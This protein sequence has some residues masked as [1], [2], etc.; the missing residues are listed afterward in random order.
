M[1]VQN[2]EFYIKL[3]NVKHW[4]KIGGIE[5]ETTPILFIHGGPGGN[6]YGF[7]KTIGLELER[8]STVIYYDQRGCGRSDQP[9]DINAYSIS[10]FISDIAKLCDALNIKKV[11][12]LG[13]S[14]GGQIA[15]EFTLSFPSYVEKLILHAPTEFFDF[16]RNYFV[17][18]FGFQSVATGKFKEKIDKVLNSDLNIEEKW[19]RVWS[20]ADSKTKLAFFFHQT[21]AAE[22]MKKIWRERSF[23]SS[24]LMSIGLQKIKNEIRLLDRVNKISVSTLIMVGLYDRNVGVELSRN[25]AENIKNSKIVIF[26]NSAHYPHIEESKKYVEVVKKFISNT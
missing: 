24:N 12:P 20:I 19:M 14:F 6:C 9:N 17:Q 3:N 1:F 8:F 13:F 2:G 15:A 22:K 11:I 10:I 7:E 26:N 5:N 25:F 21:D 4:C 16:Y 18:V 23:K